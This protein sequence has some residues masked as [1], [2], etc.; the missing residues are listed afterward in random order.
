M[1]TDAPT[2][3]RITDL[4]VFVAVAR[5]ARHEWAAVRWAVTVTGS[6]RFAEL[7]DV[8][9][10]A[11][12]LFNPLGGVS[13]CTAMGSLQFKVVEKSFTAV[14]VAGA[15]LDCRQIAQ[16]GHELTRRLTRLPG[17]IRMLVK[18]ELELLCTFVGHSLALG[19]NW[20]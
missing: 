1:L 9:F 3:F 19:K 8:S 7:A 14:G 18:T 2:S 6:A 12:T 10:G 4:G 13:G 16:D 20:Q 17:V 11:L 15:D 5:D